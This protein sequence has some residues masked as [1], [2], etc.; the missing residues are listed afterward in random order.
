MDNNIFQKELEYYEKNKQ[1]FL[2]NYQNQFLL[3]K[4]EELFGS[5]TNEVDAYKTG[6]EKF[7]NEAFLIKQVVKKETIQTNYS[8][9]SG[10]IHASL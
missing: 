9:Y 2:K 1:S 6:V 3:I 7:G 10:L 8:L 4:G 5:F